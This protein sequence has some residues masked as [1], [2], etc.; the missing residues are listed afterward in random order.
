MFILW[1]QSIGGNAVNRNEKKFSAPSLVL[2]LLLLGV[3][4]HGALVLAQSAG[5]FTAT[6]NMITPRFGHTATLLPD[7]RVLIAG[8]NTIA[9]V[10]APYF[11]TNSADLY[12][13][14]TGMFASTGNMSAFDRHTGG[15][16]LPDGRV[17]FASFGASDQAGTLA[18]V[19]L[20][21]PAMGSFSV[22][23]NTAT[24]SYVASATLLKDG[25]VLIT[26][27]AGTFRS[28]VYGAEI[29]DPATGTSA[30]VTNWPAKDDP[31]DAVALADGRILFQFYEDFAQVYD[32]A[33]GTFRSTGGLGGFDGPPRATVLLNGTVL[34]SGGN[35]IGGSE[36]SVELYDPAAGKFAANTKMSI[37]R[38]G[39]SSTLLPDGTILLAGGLELANRSKPAVA[40]VEIWDSPSGSF[41]AT[42]YLGDGRARHAAVLLNNG[43]VLIT[44]G[45]RFNSQNSLSGVS[46][47]ELY[48]PAVL[49]P[50]PSLLSVSGNGRGQGAILHAGTAQIVSAEN[51]AVAGEA[52]EMYVTGLVDGSVIPPQVSISGRLAEVLYFGAAPGYPGYNQVNFRLPSGVAPGPAVVLRLTYLGRS[53]NEVTIGVR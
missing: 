1:V 33:L 25:R 38:D 15:V 49:V 27:H 45:S 8:G 11:E 34:F 22:A 48:T 18:I 6:G 44:G 37:A 2:P 29:F 51:P 21:D 30:P 17:F 39:H 7:G 41:F 35:D 24:L 31:F 40:S 9:F 46:S 3:A 26:G 5:T 19:E 28:A 4:G 12:D 42:G 20:Y 36:S 32:P 10:G 16:L 47:A 53:S 50:A 43:Q 14:A 13:P 52:L 23:C